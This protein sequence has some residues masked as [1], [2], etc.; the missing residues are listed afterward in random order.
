M[1]SPNLAILLLQIPLILLLTRL[2][3]KGA[4]MLGLAIVVGEMLAGILLGPS[5]F[6]HLLPAVHAALFPAENQDVLGL[7]ARTGVWLY[8][9]QTGLDMDVSTLKQERRPVALLTLASTLLPFLLGALLAWPLFQQGYFGKAGAGAASLFL[10][11]CFAITALPVLARLLDEFNLRHSRP[12]RWALSS[13][14]ASDLLAWLVMA[15]LLGAHDHSGLLVPGML[16]V[17]IVLRGT[18][19]RAIMQRGKPVLLL[20]LP[21]YFVNVGLKTDFGS[22]H[23]SH[24]LATL[25]VLLAA[26]G[27][28][29]LAGWLCG[30]Y[31]GLD[32]REAWQLGL[33]LNTRGLMELILLEQG[34]QAGLLGPELY[35]MLVLMT[36]VTTVMAA[37]LLR[38]MPRPPLPA[39][40]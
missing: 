27:S 38:W 2:F 7:L 29:L 39:K 32:T 16:L 35:S 37:P 33:M 30:R 17:G 36:L 28:K 15:L 4:A 11:L 20:L 21:F 26:L 24:W 12:G 5:L 40:P 31:L 13:S 34:R 25:A 6:G 9:L 14:A 1:S 22:L 8:M 23:G 19:L 10:G 18:P 3:G